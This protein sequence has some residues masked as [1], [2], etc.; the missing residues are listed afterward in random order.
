[1]K[2]FKDTGF[3]SRRIKQILEQ[4]KIGK[5]KPGLYR[6][7]DMYGIGKFSSIEMAFC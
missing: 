6:L 3:H 7:S 5:I 1:M 4:G 2:D